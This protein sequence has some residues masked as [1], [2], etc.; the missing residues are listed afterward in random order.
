MLY[1]LHPSFAEARA[2]SSLAIKFAPV[3]HCCGSLGKALLQL[4]LR[5]FKQGT[6]VLIVKKQ[7]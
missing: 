7:L 3:G 4:I 5:M 6:K 1:V 2:E